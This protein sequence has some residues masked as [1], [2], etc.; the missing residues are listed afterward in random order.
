MSPHF[1]TRWV[2]RLLGLALISSAFARVGVHRLSPSPSISLCFPIHSSSPAIEFHSCFFFPTNVPAPVGRPITHFLGEFPGFGLALVVWCPMLWS[3]RR[4]RSAHE[5]EISFSN[6]CPGRG[7]NSFGKIS[8]FT[9][10]LSDY[11]FLVIDQVFPIFPFFSQIFRIFYYV[12]CLVLP[13]PHKKNRYFRKEFLYDAFFKT[14]LA[15]SRASDN[16]TS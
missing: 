5:A 6:L 7:V 15:L 14:L 11:L 3:Q 9:A 10:K 12:K 4:S 2:S 1:L 16:T 13:F 8:I